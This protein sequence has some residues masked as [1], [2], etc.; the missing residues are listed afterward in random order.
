[1]IQS[2]QQSTE[3]VMTYKLKTLFKALPDDILMRIIPELDD[4]QSVDGS[5]LPWN[6]RKRRRLERAKQIVLHLFSGPDSKYWE[7]AIQQ[8]SVEMLCIDLQAEISA[9]LRD[10]HIYRYLLS[11]AASG[12]VKAIIGGPPCRTVSALWYQ[13][14]GGP[15]IL[16]TEEYPYGL[17]TLSSSEQALVT[18]DSVLLF[19]MLALYMLCADV[20]HEQE[21]QTA[22]AVEQPEDPARYR[23]VAEVQEKGFTSIWRT[24]E[25][26]AFAD[27]YDVTLLHFDQGPMG[28]VKRKPTTLAVKLCDVQALP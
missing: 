7:K 15:G 27:A 9:D 8:G 4:L 23:P 20:R 12:K 1:M 21:P 6:R 19:R 11:L 26:Q 10:D 28:H 18:G 24:Q 13:E 14:D 22:L 25:W 16:R 3:M 17:P 2:I 5:R